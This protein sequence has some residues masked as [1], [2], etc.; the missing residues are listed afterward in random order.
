M[1]KSLFY[2]SHIV[3]IIVIPFKFQNQIIYHNHRHT[4]IAV[5]NLLFGET[6]NDK[7]F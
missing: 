5:T 2:M 7:L 3:A 4:C 6:F 1:D